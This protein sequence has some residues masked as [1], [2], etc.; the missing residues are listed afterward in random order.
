MTANVTSKTGIPI[1]LTDER[2]IHIS[3][4]HS[5]L[6]GMRLEVLETIADPA[7]IYAGKEGEI[8]AIKEAAGGKWLVTVYRELQNDGFVITAF[9]TGRIAS[10]ERRRQLWP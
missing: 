8:L 6:A 2:W 1:R 9:L 10:L 7:R 3:E 5:E 4:E